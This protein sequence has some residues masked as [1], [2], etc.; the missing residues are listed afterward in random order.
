MDHKKTLDEAK[1]NCSSWQESGGKSGSCFKVIYVCDQQIFIQKA[2][3]ES[4]R[5]LRKSLSC[6]GESMQLEFK[7]FIYVAAVGLRKRSIEFGFEMEISSALCTSSNDIVTY[8]TNLL[9][10]N[11][12]KR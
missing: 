6:V 5:I 12:L 10:H 11:P 8:N 2:D 1:T 4:E 9:E 3:Q 7:R